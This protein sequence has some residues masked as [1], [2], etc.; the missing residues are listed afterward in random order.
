VVV[1]WLSRTRP[2]QLQAGAEAIFADTG[3]ASDLP[4]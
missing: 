2:T 4:R 1:I 3:S